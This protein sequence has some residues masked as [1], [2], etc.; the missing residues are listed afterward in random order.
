MTGK[1]SSRQGQKGAAAVE[2]ALIGIVFFTLLLG[3]I[4]FGRLLFTWNSV[5]EA[6]RWG[7]RVAVVCD[8]DDPAIKERMRRVAGL[9]TDGNITVRYLNPPNA[10]NTC[11]KTNCKSVEVSVSGATFTPLIPFLGLTL[12]IPPFTTAL[13]RESMESINGAGELNPICQ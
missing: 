11:D 4:E 2:F 3:I 13:P 8:K 9:L 10:V 7:A 6:T 1:R 5:A 12:T